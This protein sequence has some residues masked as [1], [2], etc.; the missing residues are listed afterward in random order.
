ML[1]SPRP[2]AGIRPVTASTSRPRRSAS[3]RLLA[4][5]SCALLGHGV[6]ALPRFAAWGQ[7]VSDA[8]ITEVLDSDQVF[9]QN[10]QATVNSVAQNRQRV[11]TQ[12]A[13]TSL[14]FNT[15]AVARLAHH[16]SLMVGPCAELS[17]G[18][19]LVN[20]TLNG[21][22]TTTMAG[23]RGTL[24]T[25]EVNEDRETL[26]KV[27]EGEV[28]VGQRGNRDLLQDAEDNLDRPDYDP[29]ESDPTESN[30]AESDPAE[31][32]PDTTEVYPDSLWVVW[33]ADRTKQSLDSDR[34]AIPPPVTPALNLGQIPSPPSNDSEATLWETVD[35]TPETVLVIGAGQ[36]VLINAEGNRAMISRLTSEDFIQFVEGPLIQDFSTELPGISDLQRTF[37]RLYPGLP[38]V[39]PILS[40]PTLIIPQ[41]QPPHYPPISLPTQPPSQ[42]PPTPNLPPISPGPMRYP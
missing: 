34:P 35:F 10:R 1:S 16:S 24:Y 3:R 32:E 21:C 19:L 13:R 28:W 18:M 5:V 14:R 20:G 23:V 9:I 26:I 6:L 17:R 36:Q 25:L 11:R 31:F 4:V 39:P 33:S 27:F 30:P 22:S 12:L 41:P 29:A 38:V 40:I 42:P 2:W 37:Q 15:G 7:T 8:T